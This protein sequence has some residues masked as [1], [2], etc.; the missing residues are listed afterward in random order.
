MYRHKRFLMSKTLVFTLLALFLFTIVGCTAKNDTKKITLKLYFVQKQ[1]SKLVPEERQ[2]EVSENM[3]LA[4]VAIRELLK[5]PKDENLESILPKNTK[6]LSIEVE[7]KLAKV[8]FSKEIG[9]FP[10]IETKKLAVSSIV[11]TLT[12]LPGIEKVSIM[13]EG[14]DLLSSDDKPYGPLAREDLDKLEEE[15]P[16]LETEITL[17]FSDDEALYLV[18]ET[19][20]VELDNKLVEEVIVEELIN[21][22]AIENHFYTIPKGTKMHSVKVEDNIAYVDFSK[23]FKK[24]HP[25]GSTGE[26]MTIYSVVNSLTELENID[27][28]VFLIEGQKEKTLS[29]HLIFDEPFYRDESLIKK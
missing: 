18:P 9:D 16:K 10:D 15:N 25:G 22:P 11:N 26:I 3:V 24:N 6:L 27:K 8:D 1:N 28:V 13:S 29:G 4:E 7:G 14:K 21:G 2:V 5:G 19:R 17:Y 12:E 23:E 20:K